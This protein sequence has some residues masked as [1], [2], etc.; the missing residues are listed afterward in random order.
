MSLTVEFY[1]AQGQDCFRDDK[2]GPVSSDPREFPYSDDI[3]CRMRCS[4]EAGPWS[5]LRRDPVDEIYVIPVPSKL[6]FGAA[7]LLA[8]ACCVYAIL[9]LLSMLD[10]ILEASSKRFRGVIKSLI[11]DVDDAIEGTNGATRSGMASINR[12]VKES[13]QVAVVPILSAGGLA[14]LIIGEM[15]FFSAQISHKTEPMA[16]VGE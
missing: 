5:P 7:T 2:Y 12:K 9:W 13:L 8:A 10:K 4:I 1:R 3:T 16:S 15:N 14:L 6:T 11:E